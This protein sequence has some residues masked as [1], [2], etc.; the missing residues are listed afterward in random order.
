M[1]T[2]TDQKASQGELKSFRSRRGLNFW[3]DFYC[4]QREDCT[5][6][7]YAAILGTLL[8]AEAHWQSFVFLSGPLPPTL[9]QFSFQFHLPVTFFLK[10][11]TYQQKNHHQRILQCY[12]CTHV[13]TL[14]HSNSPM[15]CPERKIVRKNQ[16]LTS[17]NQKFSLVSENEFFYSVIPPA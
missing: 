3:G 2:F 10:R 12:Q 9:K 13:H 16:K 15:S 14:T 4:Y 17:P 7:Q 5:C 11:M 6:H 8:M 1:L